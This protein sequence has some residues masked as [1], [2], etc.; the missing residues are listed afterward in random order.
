MEKGT[1]QKCKLLYLLK[2]F[3]E[4]TDE[5]HQL[6]LQEMVEKLEKNEISVGYK[7]LLDDLEMLRHC[8]YDIITNKDNRAYRYYLGERE[9][10][11]AELKLLVDSVQASKF[12][13]EKKSKELIRKLENLTSRHRAK[14]LHRQVYIS[15]RVKAVNEAIYYNVDAIHNA[16]A[17]DVKI[18]FQYFRWDAKKNPVLRHNGAVYDVSPWGLLW[19]DEIIILW[20]MTI[21]KK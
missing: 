3:T 16:I 2:I 9:F 8:G 13:T 18:T 15:G 17:Q 5:E 19:E 14:Q 12:I 10:E 7:T 6:S 1:Y 11:I 20:D 21:K 4:E